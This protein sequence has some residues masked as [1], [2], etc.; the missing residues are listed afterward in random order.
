[1]LLCS[2]VFCSLTPPTMRATSLMPWLRAIPK[3][4]YRTNHFMMA[5]ESDFWPFDKAY[6]YLEMVSL[7]RPLIRI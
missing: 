2:N 4:E 6:L 5:D 3:R 7:K 1:M